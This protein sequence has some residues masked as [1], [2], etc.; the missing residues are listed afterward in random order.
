MSMDSC[1]TRTLILHCRNASD[2]MKYDPAMRVNQ[3]P[4]T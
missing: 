1:T 3:R 2:S 4:G